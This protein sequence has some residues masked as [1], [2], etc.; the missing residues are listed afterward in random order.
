MTHAIITFIIVLIVILPLTVA[1]LGAV[2]VPWIVARFCWKLIDGIASFLLDV[3]HG[4][5]DGA[6][7]FLGVRTR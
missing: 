2:F 1:M 6:D 4:V 3:L 5:L 7:S